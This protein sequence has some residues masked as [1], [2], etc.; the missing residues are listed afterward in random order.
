M[1]VAIAVTGGIA[2]GSA[3][4]QSKIQS[5]A[6]K[7]AAKTQADAAKEA[8]NFQQTQYEQSRQ[9]FNPYQQAGAASLG[10][11]GQSAMQ[12]RPEFR[13]G[14]PQPSFQPPTPQGFAG[15]GPG[16]AAQG[17]GP[18]RLVMMRGPDGAQKQV[19]EQLAQQLMT[20]GFQRV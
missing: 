9:D 5:H 1:C 6:A 16:L 4:A 11:L 7:S 10:R 18:S 13:P 14:Q 12:P 8:R 15:A 3:I 20:R 17:Q 2:A 19:P